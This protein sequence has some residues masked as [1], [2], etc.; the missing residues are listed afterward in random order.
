M[1]QF[2]R[3]FIKKLTNNDDA[4]RDAHIL[5]LFGQPVRGMKRLTFYHRIVV[6]LISLSVKFKSADY[7]F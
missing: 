3:K 6:Y 2:L 7:I 1:I 5:H 4:Q